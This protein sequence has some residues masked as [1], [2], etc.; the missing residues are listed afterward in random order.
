MEICG[1]RVKDLARWQKSVTVQYN[2]A[3]ADYRRRVA[4]ST[5]N[6]YTIQNQTKNCCTRRIFSIQVNYHT[7]FVSKEQNSSKCSIW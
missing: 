4:V 1:V 6:I 2:L 7:N 5:T 3:K